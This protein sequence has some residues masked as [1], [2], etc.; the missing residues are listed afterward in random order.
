MGSRRDQQCAFKAKAQ[1]D[2][3]PEYYLLIR[4]QR[5]LR[6]ERQTS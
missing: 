2:I 5:V 3:F 4:G 6:H 1:A